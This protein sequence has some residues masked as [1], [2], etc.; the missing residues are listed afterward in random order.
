MGD[1]DTSELVR[2][3]VVEVID[4]APGDVVAD[5]RLRDDLEMD[6]IDLVEVGHILEQ[7]LGAEI[8]DDEIYDVETI[9]GLIA[10]VEAKR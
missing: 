7:A 5:A 10:L 2:K 1:E 8:D 3:A 9:G 4:C 6:S